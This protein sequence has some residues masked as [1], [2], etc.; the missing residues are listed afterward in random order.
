MVRPR[1]TADVVTCVQYAA[2]NQLAIHARGAGSGLAGESLGRGLVIDFSHA[3][4]KILESRHADRVRV[5][6]GVILGQ[7][8]AQLAKFGRCFGPDPANRSVTT[9]GSVIAIDAGGSHWLRYG[10]ARR[11]S[12]KS[13]QGRSGER[14]DAHSG[15]TQL[16]SGIA[17]RSDTLSQLVVRVG[18]LI[19]GNRELIA[20]SKTR[21]PVDRCGYQLDDI[22]SGDQVDLARLLVGSEGTLALFTEA[23]LATQR[24]ATCTGAWSCCCSTDSRSAA[25]AA[26]E[27]SPSWASVPAT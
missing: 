9:M 14:R 27:W 26:I 12:A 24:I 2:E 5:Q 20:Q 7:L 16:A 18:N 19:R 13:L 21:A 6:P 4:R 11:T 17:S 3:M 10:S 23:T 8:N 1:G 15:S 25:N 22:V